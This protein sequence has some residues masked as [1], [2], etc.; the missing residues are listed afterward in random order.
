MKIHALK[1][2]IFIGCIYCI[3]SLT[4]AMTIEISNDDEYAHFYSVK[5]AYNLTIRAD[6]D[7][8]IAYNWQWHYPRQLY[9]SAGTSN[10]SYSTVV[11]VGSS[12]AG[13]YNI[14]AEADPSGASSDASEVHICEVSELM[15]NYFSNGPL[16]IPLNTPI[17]IYANSNPDYHYRQE[18]WEVY[19]PPD[20]PTWDVNSYPSGADQDDVTMVLGQSDI[21]IGGG[22]DKLTFTAS[23]SG[24][25]VIRAKAGSSD[26]GAII[27]VIVGPYVDIGS[28]WWY[29]YI[30]GNNQWNSTSFSPVDVYPTGGDY[31]WEIV[32]GT[33]HVSVTDNDGESALLQLLS[34]SDAQQDVELKLT[35]TVNGH[36]FSDSALL[37]IKTP[38]STDILAKT[39]TPLT[40]YVIA[41]KFYHRLIDQFDNPINMEGIPIDETFPGQTKPDWWTNW[42]TSNWYTEWIPTENRYAVLDYLSIGYLCDPV[43]LYQ[44]LKVGNTLL[45]IYKITLSYQEVKIEKESQE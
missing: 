25:Y 2:I 37:T 45:T 28:D 32:S 8:D 30:N 36:S 14:S 15:D 12:T 22:Y 39:L 24:K 38:V 16:Y 19:F 5:G 40:Q 35:Y 43:T 13:T 17:D 23:V 29:V 20:Y 11:N 33:E 1:F 4:Y 27:T 7:P 3:T 18:D 21:I 26:N 6:A 10:S 42:T 9:C 31:L 44:H 41:R 34:P